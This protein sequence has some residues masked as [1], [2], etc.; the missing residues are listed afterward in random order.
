MRV[1]PNADPHPAKKDRANIRAKRYF[2]SVK[3]QPRIPGI[4]LGED[5]TGRKELV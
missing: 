2:D 3:L 5:R 4:R 1:S